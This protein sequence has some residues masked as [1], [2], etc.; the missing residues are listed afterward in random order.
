MF[1][2]IGQSACEQGQESVVVATQHPFSFVWDHVL[3]FLCLCH[4]P[5][6]QSVAKGG[7]LAQAAPV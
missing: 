7:F 4:C 2:D 6:P 5:G 3:I 1:M